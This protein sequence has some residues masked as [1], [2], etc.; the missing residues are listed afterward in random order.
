[1]S[2]NHHTMQVNQPT[3]SAIFQVYYLTFMYSS[4]CFER[5]YAHHQEFNNYSSR[6]LFYRWSVVV[7]VL[8]DM[9]WPAGRPD[10]NQ[11]IELI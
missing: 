7:A 4:T 8:L 11:K 6:L 5:P 10:H 2:V 9:V 1:M 3:D